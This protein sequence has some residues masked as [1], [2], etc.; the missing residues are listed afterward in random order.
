MLAGYLGKHRS[1]RLWG[2]WDGMQIATAQTP[3]SLHVAIQQV[4]DYRLAMGRISLP[5]DFLALLAGTVIIESGGVR[6]AHSTAGARGIM[7]LSAE[8]LRDCG[9]ADR[10]QL[11]RMAQIDCAL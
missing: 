7:Q 3:V 8:V 9:I 5:R 11:H 2:T 6:E 10:F 1:A 4:Y